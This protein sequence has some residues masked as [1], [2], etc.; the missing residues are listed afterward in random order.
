MDELARLLSDRGTTRL[1]LWPEV[2][3]SHGARRYDQRFEPRTWCA[4]SR[5]SRR[6]SST[7]TRGATAGW[8]RRWP[9]FIA[10]LVGEAHASAQA[11]YARVLKTEEVRF[12]EAAVM[13]SVLHH[14][15]VGILLAE[16]DGTVS[17]ATPPVSRLSA[18]PCA[19][20]WAR[21]RSRTLRRCWP[22]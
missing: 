15:D 2:V 3:R 17:F 16:V 4:S 18:C 11:S 10:E 6:C 20:W 13:E 8:S 7:S 14:V 21:G 19:R 12:R 1:R 9:S 22:R 5:P